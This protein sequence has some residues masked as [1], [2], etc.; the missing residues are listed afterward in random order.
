MEDTQKNML[1]VLVNGTP[2]LEYDRNKELSKTQTESLTRMQEKLNQGLE[3]DNQVIKHPSL[4]QR[5]QFVSANLISAILEDNEVLAAASCA[6]IAHA[7]PELKQ[8]KAVEQ[9]GE[10]GIE[11]IFDREYQPEN[12]L[13]FT[14][15]DKIKSRLN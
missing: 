7:L 8:I 14:P 5:V 2:M 4:E 15:I 6:Y 12:T 10:I 13:S 1:V 3:L 9:A 11:L